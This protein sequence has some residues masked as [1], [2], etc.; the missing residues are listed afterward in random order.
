MV[1][2]LALIALPSL[3]NPFDDK[4]LCKQNE[5]TSF[6]SFHVNSSL[7]NERQIAEIKNRLPFYIACI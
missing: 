2:I 5:K 1:L 4:I 7:L 3:D 6:Q